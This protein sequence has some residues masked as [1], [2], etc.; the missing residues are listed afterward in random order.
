MLLHVNIKSWY[1]FSKYQVVHICHWYLQVLVILL[2]LTKCCQ[3]GSNHFH[4][5]RSTFD[6]SV[7]TPVRQLRVAGAGPAFCTRLDM[8]A[9]VP[10]L[11][12]GILN[13][14]PAMI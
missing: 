7:D 13:M 14:I 1:W 4:P 9:V 3:I 10:V 6:C 12:A 2:Q 5:F 11:V 8:Y